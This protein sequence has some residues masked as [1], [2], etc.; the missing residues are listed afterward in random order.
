MCLFCSSLAVW[1]G[2]RK[3][4]T[5]EVR[6]EETNEGWREEGSG[7]GTRGG[8]IVREIERKIKFNDI[9]LL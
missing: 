5:D 4:N 6:V 8:K 7:I 9:V 2:G 1:E 3:E